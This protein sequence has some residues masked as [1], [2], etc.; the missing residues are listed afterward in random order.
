MKFV[1]SL[2]AQKGD[3]WAMTSEKKIDDGTM[4][5]AEL[6]SA[7]LQKAHAFEFP[8]SLQNEFRQMNELEFVKL[9]RDSVTMRAYTTQ[10]MSI[11]PLEKISQV[12]FALVSAEGCILKLYGDKAQVDALKQMGLKSGVLLDLRNAG[13]NAVSVGLEECVALTSICRQ[14]THPLLQRFALCCAPI[15]V[16]RSDIDS[17][18]SCIGGVAAIVPGEEYRTEHLL[19]ACS[20]AGTVILHLSLS[21]DIFIMYGKSD[22]CRMLL[23]ENMKTGQLTINHHNRK[24]FELFGIEE[25]NLYF[26][27]AQSIFDPLPANRP[28]WEAISSG[29]MLD[30]VEMRVSVH[31]TERNCLVKLI[32]KKRDYIQSMSYTL[33]IVPFQQSV[34]EISGRVNNNAVK[35]FDDVIGRSAVLRSTIQRAKLLA[36]TDSNIMIFGESGV[37]KD[38]FA[39]AIHN[40][41]KRRNK[42]FIAIN[43]GALPRDLIG[44][45]LFG[46][47]GGAFTGAR[48]QGN[49]GKFELANGGTIFLDELGELPL[50]LQATL[51]R[52]VEQKKLMRLGGNTLIDVDVKIISATNADI[53]GMIEQKRFREDLFY[54]LST[55]SLKIPPLRDRGEDII[56]LAEEFVRSISKR[57]GKERV[58][59]ISPEAKRMLMSMA[60]RGNVRELQNLMECIVQ[61]YEEPAILPSHIAENMNTNPDRYA[62]YT[63]ETFHSAERP[64][65]IPKVE[66]RT[67][68]LTAEQILHALEVCGG[69]RS[70]AARYL[71]IAR[72][73]FYRNLERLHITLGEEGAQDE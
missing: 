59:A 48:R 71:G 54:R 61:L 43:C 50:D 60:W 21:Q 37:G 11:L 52:V 46:Y 3:D 25:Q 9:R 39:Q 45:E 47:E 41:S 26:Q 69:N 1:N 68:L 33:T 20:V 22:K 64:A 4:A 65:L 29:Q 24:V 51:L 40:N 55:V 66:K 13:V 72:K 36:G 16:M 67:A 8:G 18:E 28:I 70:A 58:M 30:D 31:G 62:V 73:T 34:D 57:L 38:V 42:P 10:A 7:Y 49:I 23:D 35:S 6:Y 5:Y 44:S 17:L 63:A 53:M 19:L 56:L 32:P 12:V 2:T 15:N 14:N 27:P